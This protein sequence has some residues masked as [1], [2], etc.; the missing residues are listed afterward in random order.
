MKRKELYII[1]HGQTDFNKNKII[2]GRGVNSNLNE[3][4][5]SQAL[6]FF[7]KYQ[8]LPFQKIYTSTLVRTHQTVAHFLNKGI[9]HESHAALDE[10]DWGIHEGMQ[11]SA[12]LKKSFDEITEAWRNGILNQGPPKGETPL[13][14]MERQ[15]EFWMNWLDTNEDLVL[16]CMHGRCMRVFLS[17]LTG[18]GLASMDTFD[19]SNTCLYHGWWD[20]EKL[21]LEKEN[22]T[23]HLD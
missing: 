22:D 3:E 13:Q 5:R 19:H 21:V 20:G 23:T 14:V 6:R 1:R 2:Q 8:H 10:F 7:E 16:I 9:P 11:T 12:E 18:R 15:K 4:G 17:W